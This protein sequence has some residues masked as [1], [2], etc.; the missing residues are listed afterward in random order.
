MGDFKLL[1][2]FFPDM[3]DNTW[4]TLSDD[5]DFL[6]HVP[7]LVKARLDSRDRVTPIDQNYM[8]L[9]MADADFASSEEQVYIS[10]KLEKYFHHEKSLLPVYSD[11]VRDFSLANERGYKR[12]M[13][14]VSEDFASKCLF[15]LA[16]LNLLW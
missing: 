2:A 9:L 8:M 12:E 7:S 14:R 10:S 11:Y 5:P 16:F 15:G 1:R 4:K 3:D 6:E 13:F